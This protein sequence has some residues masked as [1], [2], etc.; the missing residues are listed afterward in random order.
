MMDKVK[1]VGIS[2]GEGNHFGRVGQARETSGE[3]HDNKKTTRPGREID[4]GVSQSVRVQLE[5]G[6]IK[7]NAGQ[8]AEATEEKTLDSNSTLVVPHGERHSQRKFR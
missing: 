6:R 4:K 5:S 2:T 3:S 1:P 8:P 7:Q